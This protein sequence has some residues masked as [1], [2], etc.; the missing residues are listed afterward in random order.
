MSYL[1]IS[2]KFKQRMTEISPK[3]LLFDELKTEQSVEGL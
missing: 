2:L 3:E 1:R